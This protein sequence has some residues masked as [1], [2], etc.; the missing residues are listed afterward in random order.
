MR[1]YSDKKRESYKTP[2]LT[3]IKDSLRKDNKQEGYGTSSNDSLENMAKRQLA[4]L[5]CQA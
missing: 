4:D 3:E 5:E 1:T 2:K